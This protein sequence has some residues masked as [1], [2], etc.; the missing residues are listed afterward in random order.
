MKSSYITPVYKDGDPQD[1][2]RYRPIS[3]LSAIPKLFEYLVTNQLTA[4]ISHLIIQEENAYV[5][6]KWTVTNLTIFTHFLADLLSSDEQLDVIFNDLS[7]EFSSVNHARLLE[8]LF[9]MGI[10]V[11]LL[12]YIESYLTG[13]TEKVKI[14]QAIAPDVSVTSGVP[15]GSHLGPVLFMIFINDVSNCFIYMLFLIFADDIKMFYKVVTDINF[16]NIQSDFNRF[17]EWCNLNGVS[18]NIGK[19]KV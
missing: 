15:Q 13:R 7:R 19:C 12:K 10:Q 3:I 11:R 4:A 17:A 6:G 5:E 8:K 16:L 1:V 9:N 14:N 18:Q 2:S